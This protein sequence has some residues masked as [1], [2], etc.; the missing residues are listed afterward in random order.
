MVF[1]QNGKCFNVIHNLSKDIKSKV[2]TN[3]GTSNY[4]SGKAG[5]RQGENLSPF[6]FSTFLNDLDTYLRTNGDSTNGRGIKVKSLLFCRSS[7]YK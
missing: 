7:G 5:V 2:M 6:L 3:E 1:G 4:F